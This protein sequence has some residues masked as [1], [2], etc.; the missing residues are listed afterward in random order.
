MALL[1]QY[2]LPRR[3]GY[4]SDNATVSMG[5]ITL[6]TMSLNLCERPV[7]PGH[8]FHCLCHALIAIALGYAFWLFI[9]FS[10][11]LKASCYGKNVSLYAWC[12]ILSL[13][14]NWYN[15]REEVWRSMAFKNKVHYLKLKK[16]HSH[17][18][19]HAF[20]MHTYIYI[21]FKTQ[22]LRGHCLHK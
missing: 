16:S 1:M 13:R 5:E 19:M 2:L 18:S 15:G 11:L 17:H 22:E 7:S 21:N 9:E 6:C 3:V 20:I 4:A 12:V 10:I 14:Y 8:R